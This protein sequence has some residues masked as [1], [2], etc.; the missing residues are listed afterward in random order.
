MINLLPILAALFGGGATVETSAIVAGLVA[1]A[2]CVAA[3]SA[4][5]GGPRPGYGLPD[6]PLTGVVHGPDDPDRPQD[7]KR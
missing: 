1:T 5:G 3:S 4:G 6:V 7:G 2:A